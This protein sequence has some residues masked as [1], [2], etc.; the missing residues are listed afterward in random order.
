MLRVFGASDDLV[1]IES[2][3]GKDDEIGC[4]DADVRIFFSDGTV[5]LVS[6]PVNG[7]GIWKITVEKA[8]TALQ[9]L[10]VCTDEDAEVYS[11]EFYIESDVMKY[12]V[13]DK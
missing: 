10:K 1:V 13:I 12:S 8:G 3:N 7:P 2:T 4:Y 5:A 9:E 6:Y 11:D